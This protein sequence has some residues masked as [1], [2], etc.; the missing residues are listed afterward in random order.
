MMIAHYLTLDGSF[1]KWIQRGLAGL[2][3]FCLASVP[4]SCLSTVDPPKTRLH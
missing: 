3:R 1:P 2:T 4:S